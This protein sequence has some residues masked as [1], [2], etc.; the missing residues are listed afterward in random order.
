MSVSIFDKAGIV[1]T[2]SSMRNYVSITWKE[3]TKNQTFSFP[4]LGIQV[5]HNSD[6]SI[7]KTLSNSLIIADFGKNPS[8]IIITGIATLYTQS[9]GTTEVSPTDISLKK[10]IELYN[11]WLKNRA[12]IITITVNSIVYKGLIM[13][14]GYKDYKEF[15]DSVIYSLSFIG[16]NE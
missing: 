4:I 9:N 8:P 6:L 5:K 10:L 13:Q 16:Y 1:R 12:N 2:G 15:N 14:L 11:T 3:D 7:Q